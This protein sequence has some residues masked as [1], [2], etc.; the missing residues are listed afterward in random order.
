M[1]SESQRVSVK[2][3][4]RILGRTQNYIRYAMDKKLIDIGMVTPSRTGKSKTYSI[5]LPKLKKLI[6]EY[7][8][9][10]ERVGGKND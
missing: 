4:A 6:G 7:E 5:F 9:E 10:H 3:A 1:G 8:E 2:E